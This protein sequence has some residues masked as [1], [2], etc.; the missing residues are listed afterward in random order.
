MAMAQAHQTPMARPFPAE[1][2]A[3]DKKAAKRSPIEFKTSIASNPT[4]FLG[5]L[6]TQ[7]GLWGT[8]NTPGVLPRRLGLFW[9][10][11]NAGRLEG[12][13]VKDH[14]SGVA[15]GL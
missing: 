5:H 2:T 12:R 14:T 6:G 8:Q 15:I 4:N 10:I 7:Q 1:T 9:V 13:C 3:V 11:A